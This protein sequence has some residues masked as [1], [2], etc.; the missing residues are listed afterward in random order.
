MPRERPTPPPF[1]SEELER[2]LDRYLIAGLVFMA[3]L[4]AGFVIYKV[5][6]P[7]LRAD[8]TAAQQATYTDL[9]QQL[10]ETNCSSC[11]GKGAVGGTAPV[12]NS[13]EFLKSASNGQ[14]EHLIAGGVSGSDMPAWSLEFGGSMTDEQILQITTYLRSLEQNAPSVPTWRSGK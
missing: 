10:F 14:I 9:G 3:L 12:L 6:E 13:K 4:I 1:E 2:S 7:H 5:R 11:H 8:A